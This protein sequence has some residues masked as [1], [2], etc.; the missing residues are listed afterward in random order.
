MS[1][2]D[3]H[4]TKGRD[5]ALRGHEHATFIDNAPPVLRDQHAT[6]WSQTTVRCSHNGDTRVDVPIQDRASVHVAV[7]L[8]WGS[9]AQPSTYNWPFEPSPT[10]IGDSP[11]GA[12]PPS[13]APV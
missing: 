11:A 3:S 2:G 4:G 12:G 9:N 5:Q 10:A 8:D 7:R 1:A 13:T 6:H